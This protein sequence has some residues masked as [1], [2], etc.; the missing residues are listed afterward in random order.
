MPNN[1]PVLIDCDYGYW[2]VAVVARFR[3]FAP[4][5]GLLTLGVG[6]AEDTPSSGGTTSDGVGCD[7]C[8]NGGQPFGCYCQPGSDWEFEGDLCLPQPT[9]T[10]EAICAQT[11]SL[12]NGRTVL[13]EVRDATC[14]ESSSISCSGWSPASKISYVAG[15]YEVDATW[16][17]GV[18]DDPAP[19]WGCDDAVVVPYGVGEFE[20]DAA[21][22]GE[23]LYELGLRDGDR[24]VSLNGEPLGTFEQAFEAF[25]MYLNSETEFDLVV[26]RGGTN[27]TLSYEIN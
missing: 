25:T 10:T 6:C 15:I 7:E 17:A 27:I 2:Y 3:L 20:I 9:D 19:L 4:L 11:C 12:A 22:S 8:P 26:N 14:E 18:I 5:L 24:P 21:S 16:L 23:A 13:S 1:S